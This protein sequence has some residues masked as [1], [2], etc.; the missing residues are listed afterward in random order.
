MHPLDYATRATG[1]S[2]S[3]NLGSAC[4]GLGIYHHSLLVQLCMSRSPDRESSQFWD[5]DSLGILGQ[6]RCF[7]IPLTL[8]AI[9]SHRGVAVGAEAL[10]CSALVTHHHP[11][12]ASTGRVT[13]LAVHAS[14]WHFRSADD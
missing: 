8:S 14:Y 4:H 10:A 12:G 3:L 1:L 2:T 7:G 6:K 9:S 5:T 13:N 11:L